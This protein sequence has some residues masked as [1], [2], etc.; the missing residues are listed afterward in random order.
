MSRIAGLVLVAVLMALVAAFP[1]GAQVQEPPK[2]PTAEG[3]GGSA[4]TVDPL[5]TQAAIDV[6]KLR[7]QRGR[8]RGRR[9]RRARRRRAVLVR[10][11]RR[12]LHGHLRRQAP[13]GR[14]HRLAAR[15]RRGPRRDR[16]RARTPNHVPGAPAPSG[17]SVGVP[18]TVRGLGDRAEPL[19]HAFAAL[20]AAA[21][22][23]DRPRG[24]RRRRRRSTSQVV[25]NA[26]VF[27]DFTSSRKPYLTAGSRAGRRRRPTATRTWRR[28]TSASA[29]TRTASTTGRIARDIAQPVQHP[30]VAADANREVAR[31]LDDDARS[32]ALQGDP[33]RA[34]E[35]RLPRARG[36][37]HGPAVLRRLDG[38]RG[39][40]HP[41][42]LPAH[43]RRPEE[44]APLPRGVQARLRGPRRVRRRPCLSRRRAAARPAVRRRS[45]PSAAR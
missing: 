36:L 5:A 39:A 16:L 37:R 32:R 20:A 29:R 17:L 25:G 3:T 2:T 24:L 28:P 1:A 4:A 6:L 27:D 35:D 10:H 19:R 38:R 23:A 9:G 40:Q 7:R 15:R 18:G 45:P 13:P 21:R 41:R 34:D 12:R 44:A 8:R 31:R 22:R 30:P 11:R 43:R 42:G 14:H 33:P 26:D